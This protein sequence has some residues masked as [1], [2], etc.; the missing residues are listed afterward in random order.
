MTTI[1]KIP[2]DAYYVRFNVIKLP[3]NLLTIMLSFTDREDSNGAIL[4]TDVIGETISD[5]YPAMGELKN[6][7][8]L[9]EYQPIFNNCYFFSEEEEIKRLDWTIFDSEYAVENGFLFN[10]PGVLQ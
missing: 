6:M 4:M 3:N 1:D 2:D 7:D 5:L 9:K 8:F 10:H